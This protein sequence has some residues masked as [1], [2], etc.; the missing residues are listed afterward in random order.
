MGGHRFGLKDRFIQQTRGAG[1]GALGGG[2][3]GDHPFLK[4]KP[5]YHHQDA[6]CDQNPNQIAADRRHKGKEDQDKRQVGQRADCG[7]SKEF[8]HRAKFAHGAEQPAWAALPGAVFHAQ[9]FFH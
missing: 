6:A 9:Q 8:A 2:R 3:Q 4:Q 1:A 5:R 7:G